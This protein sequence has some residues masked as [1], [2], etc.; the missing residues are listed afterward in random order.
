MERCSGTKLVVL[1][2][3]AQVS[4]EMTACVSA[5]CGLLYPSFSTHSQTFTLLLTEKKFL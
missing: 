2:D 1:P 3:S 4:G 5:Y